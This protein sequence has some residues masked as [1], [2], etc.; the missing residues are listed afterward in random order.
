VTNIIQ[1][2]NKNLNRENITLTVETIK[3]NL[4]DVKLFHINETISAII[5]GLLQQMALAGFDVTDDESKVSI[6]DGAF[7]VEAMKS[8]LCR[9]HNI[10]HPFQK[11]AEE[12]FINQHEDGS[13]EM[14]EELSLNLIIDNLVEE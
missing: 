12:I 3:S 8:M 11:I 14:A 2:P 9:H 13:L 5:P 7:L 6:K 4:D 1:F 10:K